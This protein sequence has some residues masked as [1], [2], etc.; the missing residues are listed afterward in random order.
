MFTTYF[1][2]EKKNHEIQKKWFDGSKDKKLDRYVLSKCC[3]VLIA[4]SR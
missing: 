3:K 4:E 1:K 2:I